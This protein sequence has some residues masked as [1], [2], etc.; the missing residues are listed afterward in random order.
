VVAFLSGLDDHQFWDLNVFPEVAELRALRFGE[1]DPK[2]QRTVAKRLRK[3]PPRNQW[4][5]KAVATDVKNARLYWAVRELKRIDVAG[6]ALPRD[7][8]SWM[9]AN[10]AKFADLM[11]MVVEYGLPEA[12][13]VHDVTLDKSGWLGRRPGRKGQRLAPNFQ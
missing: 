10:L 8:Q 12:T 1:L 3:G 6:G 9:Q 5:R 7:A 4:P 13:E 11:Q 2:D